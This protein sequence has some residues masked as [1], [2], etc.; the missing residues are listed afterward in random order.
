MQS[1]R[2][3]AGALPNA[4]DNGRLAALSRALVPLESALSIADPSD[5]TTERLIE[6]R[7]QISAISDLLAAAY[8]R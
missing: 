7:A 4:L 1:L 5:I 2:R 3:L 8:L 6:I